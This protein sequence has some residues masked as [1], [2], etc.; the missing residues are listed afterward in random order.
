[1]R[2]RS[3][4]DR[5]ETNLLTFSATGR[6]R[7]ACS[8]W[9]CTVDSLW[10]LYRAVSIMSLNGGE[11]TIFAKLASTFGSGAEEQPA[12]P[13]ENGC[14]TSACWLS[15]SRF[16]RVE[17]SVWLIKFHADS[18]NRRASCGSAPLELATYGRKRSKS[19]FGTKRRYKLSGHVH[20]KP[21][22][23]QYEHRNDS[24]VTDHLITSSAVGCR[25]YPQPA[26]PSEDELPRSERLRS[27][28]W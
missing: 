3:D 18:C 21:R 4:S 5:S 7:S 16:F 20:C 11:I 17:S 22:M 26:V 14:T 23:T 28:I 8:I 9:M 24:N 15:T 25:R 10:T 13:A 2:A 6:E 27:K 19:I 12:A 1:M